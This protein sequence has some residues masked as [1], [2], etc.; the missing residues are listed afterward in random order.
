MNHSVVTPWTSVGNLVGKLQVGDLIEIKRCNNFGIP[1]YNHWAVYIG[2]RNGVHE[3][4]H[5][6]N[7]KIM[8]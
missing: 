4:G 7:G 6:N 5:F 1:I 2:I 3:I 8:V